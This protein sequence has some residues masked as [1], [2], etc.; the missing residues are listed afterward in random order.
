MSEQI[1]SFNKGLFSIEED[2]VTANHYVITMY[3]ENYD[4]QL[5]VFVNLKDLEELRDYLNK[6]L[7]NK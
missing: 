6:L 5:M 7:T 3:S 2:K 1:K 4:T